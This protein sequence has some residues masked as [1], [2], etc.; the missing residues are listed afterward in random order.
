MS[1]LTTAVTSVITITSNNA[2]TRG[3]MFF[4][5]FVAAATMCSYPP[6]NDTIKSATGSAN[7]LPYAASS[8][9]K[10]FETPSSFAAAA[11]AP[12]HPDDAQST[13]TSPKDLAAVTAFAVASIANS[14]PFT[15]A[16]T[17]TAIIQ[18]PLLLVLR[19]TRLLNQL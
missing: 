7:P 8:A 2:A 15:S 6:A 14:A 3:K 12:P 17:R 4:A 5:L 1:P 13:V 18:P 10:T 11:A 19:S 9:H 16:N